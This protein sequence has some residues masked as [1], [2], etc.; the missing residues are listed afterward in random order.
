MEDDNLISYYYDDAKTLY[1]VFQR[2]LQVS[3]DNNMAYLTRVAHIL[4]MWHR[5]PCVVHHRYIS[6]N[7]T[8]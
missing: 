7:L 5:S 3:G 4:F 8:T 6:C 2:G 1:E